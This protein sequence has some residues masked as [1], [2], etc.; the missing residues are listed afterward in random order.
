M[1]QRRM[2]SPD[3][4]CSDAFLDMPTSSQALYYSLGMYADDDGFVNPRK[5]MRMLGVA[6]DDLKILIGKRFVLPFA[7]GVIVIKHWKINNLVRKD[8]YRPTQYLEER[9][10]LLVKENGAYTDDLEQ[11]PELVNDSLTVRPRRLGKDSIGNTVVADAPTVPLEVVEVKDEDA[12]EK[13]ARMPKDDKALSLCKWA[14]DRRGF[15]FVSV[16]AQ[17]G[18]IGRAKKAKVSPSKLK[19]RWAELEEETWRNGFD[20]LDVVKSFDKRA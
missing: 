10:M 20:W 15:P 11:Y 3:I 17:L 16:P 19:E 2:F 9:A 7:S 1:A 18:A 12:P 4:V 5:I 14:E 6:E 8:W 13:P